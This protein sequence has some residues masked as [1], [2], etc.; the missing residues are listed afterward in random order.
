MAVQVVQALMSGDGCEG[1]GS[2]QRGRMGQGSG[3][4]CRWQVGG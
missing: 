2:W 3:P 1:S 4:M